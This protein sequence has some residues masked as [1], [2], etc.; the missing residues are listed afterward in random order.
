VL[1][2]LDANIRLALE[3]E[4]YGAALRDILEEILEG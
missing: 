4:E 2:W 3:T 1:S